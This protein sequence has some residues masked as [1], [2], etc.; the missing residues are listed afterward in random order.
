MSLHLDVWRDR[1]GYNKVHIES[2]FVCGF[3]KEVQTLQFLKIII[4]I[5]HEKN[6]FILKSFLNWEAFHSTER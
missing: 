1:E 3:R 2:N 4:Y 5:E 6:N